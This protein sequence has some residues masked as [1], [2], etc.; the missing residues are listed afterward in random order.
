MRGVL[1]ALLAGGA[2]VGGFLVSE[3]TGPE[4]PQRDKFRFVT[5]DRAFTYLIDH[6]TVAGG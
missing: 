5:V 6:A 2:V 1:A 3:E 4:I